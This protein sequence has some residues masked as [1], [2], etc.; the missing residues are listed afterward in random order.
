MSVKIKGTIVCNDDKWIYEWFGIEATSPK[1][2]EKALLDE[3]EKEIVIEVNSGGGDVFAGNEIYYLIKKQDK[4]TECNITGFAG[5]AAT[6][7]CCAADT[8]AAVPGAQYMIHNVS[9]SAQG[10]YNSMNKA[11]EILQTANKTIANVYRL[12]TGMTEEELLSLM[13]QETWMD[14]TKAMKLGFV[15]TVMGDN[16]NLTAGQPF[17]IN[18]SFANILSDE[19]KEKIRAAIKNPSKDKRDSLMNQERLNLLKMKGAIRDEI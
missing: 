12:K 11:S 19:V 15:D 16:G 9:T 13:N 4:K 2:V 10:D 7:I 6:I 18:N 3:N 1:D 5:S 8:V 14:V 17:T